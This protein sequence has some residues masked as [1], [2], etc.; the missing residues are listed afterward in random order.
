MGQK[1]PFAESA[2]VDRVDIMVFGR[3]VDRAV[4]PCF[5]G[6][7]NKILDFKRPFSLAIRPDREDR[8]IKRTDVDRT[9]RADLRG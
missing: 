5:G 7:K 3:D 4:D 9:I 6:R 8:S 1:A 2:G